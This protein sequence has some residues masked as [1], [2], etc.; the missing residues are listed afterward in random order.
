M[1]EWKQEIRRR[2]ASLKL[3]PTREG[4]ILEELSQH[5]DD[6]YEGLLASGANEAEAERRT[7]AEL[8]DSEMLQRELRRG[9]GQGQPAS[10]STR[11]KRRGKDGGNLLSEPR[12]GGA[13][14][15]G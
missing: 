13:K 5:L 4:A 3:E 8:S 14:F 2:L 12:Y 15:V 10:I 6:C 7:M 9:G 1:P 11:T